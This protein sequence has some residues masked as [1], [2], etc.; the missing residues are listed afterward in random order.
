MSALRGSR[1][2]TAP[3]IVI[4]LVAAAVLLT[5]CSSDPLADQYREG[6]SK[7]YI[8]GDGSITEIGIAERGEPIDFAGDVHL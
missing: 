7:G 5:G 1:R 6:S 4:G 3:R 8:A 2:R